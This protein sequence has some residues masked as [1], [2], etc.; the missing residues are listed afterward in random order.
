MRHGDDSDNPALAAALSALRYHPRCMF[1]GQIRCAGTG[2]GS[3]QQKVPLGGVSRGQCNTGRVPDP[4]TITPAPRSTAAAQRRVCKPAVEEKHSNLGKV[5]SILLSFLL[6]AACLTVKVSLLFFCGLGLVHHELASFSTAID[7][8]HS[9][10][11]SK[12]CF[13]S[14]D[15]PLMES[16]CV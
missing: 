5:S 13:C 9:E 10:I 7:M 14:K 1:R 4:H 16:Q 8:V 11:A 12:T 2:N 3:Q 15:L 6:P